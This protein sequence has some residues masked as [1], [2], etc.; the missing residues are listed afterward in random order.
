[1]RHIS[2]LG[3]TA[4]LVEALMQTTPLSVLDRLI[5]H[6]DKQLKAMAGGRPEHIRPSPADSLDNSELSA[7]QKRTSAGL[8]R[9]NHAGEVCAQGLYE[10]QA[11]TAKLPKVREQVREAADE[12]ED[13]LHWC[14]K[15]LDELGSHTS[16]LNPFWYSASFALGAGAGLISDRVSLGFVAATEEQV[17]KHLQDHLARLPTEDV[18]SRAVVETMLD[19]EARHA[20]S[21][22]EAG[23]IRFPAPVKAA[24]T[25][26]SKA[27]T[28]ASYYI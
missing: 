24:M 19:D 26:T 9:V 1:M 15:R 27:M 25:L 23:G 7:E 6:A 17:C 12:E 20:H 4:P 14:Q 5:L 2:S 21:A 8:M 3:V 22:L 11:L 13:H 16:Y 10:G 28:V 18:K